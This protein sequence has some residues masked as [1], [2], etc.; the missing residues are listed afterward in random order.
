MNRIEIDTFK[1]QQTTAT[2]ETKGPYKVSINLSLFNIPKNITFAKTNGCIDVHFFYNDLQENI[3]I[4]KERTPAYDFYINRIDG[5]LMKIVVKD[6]A[7]SSIRDISI[8]MQKVSDVKSSN[9]KAVNAVLTEYSDQVEETFLK[10][11]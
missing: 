1:I 8:A 6:P 11:A 4:Q 2:E 7:A 10:A 5:K 3:D 9:K